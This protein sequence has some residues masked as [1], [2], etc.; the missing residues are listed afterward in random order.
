MGPHNAFAFPLPDFTPYPTSQS[1]TVQIYVSSVNSFGQSNFRRNKIKNVF[2]SKISKVIIQ[3]YIIIKKFYHYQKLI[4][5]L[6]IH[7]FIEGK[8]AD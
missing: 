3:I 5:G 8:V 2:I 1:H 4:S 7:I 6:I